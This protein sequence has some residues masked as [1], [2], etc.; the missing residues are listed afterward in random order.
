MYF[1][2]D[3]EGFLKRGRGRGC[4]SQSK[5]KQSKLWSCD[6]KKMNSKEGSKAQDSKGR[7]KV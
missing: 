5:Q 2:R 7:P 4:D 6:G 1:E 3:N